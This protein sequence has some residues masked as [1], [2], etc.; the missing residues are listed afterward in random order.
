MTETYYY[1]VAGFSFSINLPKDWEMEALLPSFH[2]FR[3]LEDVPEKHLFDFIVVS[4]LEMP[5]SDGKNLLEENE[6]DM[7][8]LKLYALSD[9][10]LVEVINGTYIHRMAVTSDFS[11]VKVCLQPQDKNLGH[12]LSSLLRIAYAQAILLHN[13]I[14]IHAAAVYQGGKA[15]LFMGTS[16]TGKSTHAS[17]WME[18]IPGTGLLNDDNPTIRIVNGKAYA[19]GTPWSGKTACYKNLSFPIGGMVRLKQAPVNRFYPQEGVDAFIAIY[20]GCSVIAQDERLRNRLYD[21][22]SEFAGSIA[23]GILECLPDKEAALMCH[24]ALLREKKE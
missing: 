2:P 8:H 17:L 3:I 22:V 4:S 9:G 20:P 18:H 6:N 19:Y 12:A 24:R 13:A 21:T 10:Y 11:T 14:S 1:C 5:E 16:G 7:G 15:Y 23:V